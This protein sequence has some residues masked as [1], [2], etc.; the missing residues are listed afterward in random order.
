MNL[1]F[2]EDETGQDNEENHSAGEIDHLHRVDFDDL[3]LQHLVDFR[4][5]CDELK[6]Q[7]CIFFRQ[8][9][10]LVDQI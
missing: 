2:G 8:A 3:A 1:N 9:Y 5:D 7:E 4:H 10:F 6:F